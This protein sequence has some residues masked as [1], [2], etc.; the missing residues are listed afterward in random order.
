MIEVALTVTGLLA[1]ATLALAPW[2]WLLQ[3]GAALM[4]AGVAFGIPAGWRYHALL[5][6]ELGRVGARV[7]GW[8]WQPTAHHRH[9]DDS[10]RRAIAPS[11]RLGAA[12]CGVIFLG[13][14]VVGVGL[15]RSDGGWPFG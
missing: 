2:P 11:F 6:R 12:G 8:W 13:A 5:H 14:F 15:L 4:A 1:M 7:P 10:G 9:L 3:G